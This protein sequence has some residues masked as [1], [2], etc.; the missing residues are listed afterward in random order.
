MYNYA[1]VT[2]NNTGVARALYTL[3]PNTQTIRFPGISTHKQNFTYIRTCDRHL[4]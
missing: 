2:A 4:S 1:F 3:W